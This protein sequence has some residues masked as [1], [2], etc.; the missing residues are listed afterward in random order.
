VIGETRGEVQKLDR[1]G[2]LLIPNSVDGIWNKVRGLRGGDIYTQNRINIP[3]G[4][5][6]FSVSHFS[7]TERKKS[8]TSAQ[9][10]KM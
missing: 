9:G 1:L 3:R 8:W 10:V 4:D 5:V 6:A 2:R 7:F